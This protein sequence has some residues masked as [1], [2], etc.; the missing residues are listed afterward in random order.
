MEA[1]SPIADYNQDVVDGIVL[2]S[3]ELH[4]DSSA[5]IKLNLKPVLDMVISRN[6]P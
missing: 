5:F 3:C 1:T 2:Y 4:N 6:T